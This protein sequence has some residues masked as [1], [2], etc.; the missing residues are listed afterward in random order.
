[1]LGKTLERIQVQRLSYYAAK[2]NLFP[3]NQY[4]GINGHSAQDPVVSIVHDIEAAWNHNRTT[5]LLTF[6]IMG[7][8]DFS[9]HSFL[10][11]TLRHFHI[12]LP[13]VRWVHSF[14]QDKQAAICLDGKR[15]ELKPVRSG[16]PQGSCISP[17][18]AAFF[19]TE[20]E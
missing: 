7:Y 11:D 2:F 1:M 20:G 19:T 8:F 16:I 13:T 5:T 14:I 15:D 4:G 10:I 18:L 17:I 6:D 3:S 12:P 9:P